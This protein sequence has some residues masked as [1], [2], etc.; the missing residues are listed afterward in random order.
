MN[1]A[2]ASAGGGDQIRKVINNYMNTA[3][4]SFMQFNTEFPSETGK[5]HLMG[6]AKPSLLHLLKGPHKHLF[7][8]GTFSS[9]PKPFYQCLIVMAWSEELGI[10]V[11]VFYS[12]QTLPIP[13]AR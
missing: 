10:Y 1:N 3:R 7:F 11:P 5:Q 13:L 9:V 6:F 4:D 12:H 2:R 8:D